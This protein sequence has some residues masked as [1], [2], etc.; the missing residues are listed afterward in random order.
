[1]MRRDLLVRRDPVNLFLYRSLFC[2][3]APFEY[4]LTMLDHVRMPAEIGNSV[5]RIQSPMIGVLPQDV[6]G[7][8]DL[9]GPVFMI[10]RTAHC[11]DIFE[12]RR[13][14]VKLEQLFSVSKL[15]WPARTVQQKKLVRAVE[16]AFFPV[17]MQRSHIA[18][19]RRNA[20]YSRDQ[21]MIRSAVAGIE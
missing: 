5:A 21:Q 17:A 1:M 2:E 10:P 13:F 11:G 15:P 3:S 18:H 14:L 7:A 9:A 12:P 8:A 6:V 20:G 19:E 4:R 16:A